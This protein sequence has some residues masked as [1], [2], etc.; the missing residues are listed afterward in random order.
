VRR[1]GLLWRSENCLDGKRQHLCCESCVPVLFRT[2]QEA[3]DYAD[4]RYGYIRT[5]PDLQTEPHGW[6]LPLPVRVAV[7]VEY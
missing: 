4:R 1:W 5:R 7:Q 6:R 2:R 3:R